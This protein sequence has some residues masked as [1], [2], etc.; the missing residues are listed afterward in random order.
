MRRVNVDCDMIGMMRVVHYLN[1]GSRF[2]DYI[3]L[4]VVYWFM[5]DNFLMYNWFMMDNFLV[6]RFRFMVVDVFMVLVDMFVSYW[7]MFSNIP[8]RDRDFWVMLVHMNSSFFNN[9]LR[10]VVD[11]VDVYIHSVV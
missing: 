9:N 10:F 6:Y 1:H 7:F 5:V 11:R 4:L 8:F 2:N 3:V